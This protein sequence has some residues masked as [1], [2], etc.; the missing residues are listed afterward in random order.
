MFRRNAS[1]LPQLVDILLDDASVKSWP[2]VISRLGYSSSPASVTKSKQ[3]CVE[4]LYRALVLID[5]ERLAVPV[6]AKA[7]IRSYRQVYA[8]SVLNALGKRSLLLDVLSTARELAAKYQL[9]MPSAII[10]HMRIGQLSVHNQDSEVLISTRQ[11]G[12]LQE[13][14]PAELEVEC[15]RANLVRLLNRPPITEHHEEPK[16]LIS[17][18]L[19]LMQHHDSIAIRTST[20]LMIVWYSNTIGDYARTIEVAG[21]ALQWLEEHRDLHDMALETNLRSNMALALQM[22]GRRSDTRADWDVLIRGAAP[23]V[24]KSHEIMQGYV[25]SLLTMRDYEEAARIILEYVNIR[26]SGV[27]EWQHHVWLVCEAY[28]AELAAAGYVVDSSRLQ[29]VRKSSSDA[30]FKKRLS[31][32]VKDK[33]QSNTAIIILEIVQAIRMADIPRAIERIDQLQKYV[34]RYEVGKQAIRT[35]RF[36]RILST[37]IAADFDPDRAEQRAARMISKYQKADELLRDDPEIIPYEDLWKIIIMYL[38]KQKQ[39]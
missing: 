38:E 1:L 23:T 4:M 35:A 37:L 32:L 3:R 29:R 11:I 17:R 2:H 25:F 7:R 19:K 15:L 28:I 39:S 21:Q 10:E 36:M 31:T 33:V 5:T 12:Q 6:I 30:G 24:A 26:P 16:Q 34:T 20:W 22:T 9:S 27:A 13:L 18:A 8:A 14:L